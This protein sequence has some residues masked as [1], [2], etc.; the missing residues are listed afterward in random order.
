MAVAYY[1][2]RLKNHRAR[3]FA[4]LI[5]SR[6]HGTRHLTHTHIQSHTADARCKKSQLATKGKEEQ[7]T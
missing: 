6:T 4:A 7:G 2:A 1:F 3:H 5:G